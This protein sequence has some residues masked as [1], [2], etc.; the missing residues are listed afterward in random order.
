MKD[1][2]CE[3]RVFLLPAVLPRTVPGTQSCLANIYE[4]NG[5]HF[6]IPLCSFLEIFES[7]SAFSYTSP[8]IRYSVQEVKYFAYLLSLSIASVVLNAVFT[9]NDFDLSL[10]LRGRL[11]KGLAPWHWL[12]LVS[13]TWYCTH[14]KP[15]RTSQALVTQAVYNLNG[16]TFGQRSCDSYVLK[17][18]CP[19]VYALYIVQ[20]QKQIRSI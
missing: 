19:H 16:A 1:A 4:V 3:G 5:N 20:V 9:L 17:R 13:G 14:W 7:L 12:H 8:N 6:R 10:P 2:Q 15:A 11:A 18:F